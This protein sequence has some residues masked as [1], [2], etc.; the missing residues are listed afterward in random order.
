MFWT[1]GQALHLSALAGYQTAL[2]ATKIGKPQKLKVLV[3]ECTF[4]LASNFT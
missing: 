4:V 1:E 2:R 3:K